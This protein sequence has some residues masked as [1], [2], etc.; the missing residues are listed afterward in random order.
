MNFG[1]V[2]IRLADLNV[3][4]AVPVFGKPGRRMAFSYSLD[5]DTGILNGANPDILTPHPGWTSG[6]PMGWFYYKTITEGC[7]SWPPITMYVFSDYTD[8]NGITH[9]TTTVT[10]TTPNPPAC[11]GDITPPGIYPVNDGSGLLKVVNADQSVSI[12]TPSGA[13]IQPVRISW[14]GTP[15]PGLLSGGSVTDT[16][17]NQI[18]FQPGTFV[19]TTGTSFSL[20]GDPFNPQSQAFA[21]TDSNGASQSVNIQYGAYNVGD[22]CSPL[23]ANLPQTV[24]YPDSSFMQFTYQ[25]NPSDPSAVTGRIASVRLQTGGTISL[26]YEASPFNNGGCAATITHITV[27]T[28][29]G[30]WDLRVVPSS[31]PD[32]SATLATTTVTDPKGNQT[33]ATFVN[34]FEIQKQMYTGSANSGTLLQTIIACYNGVKTNCTSA[35]PAGLV[36][37]LT[38]FTLLPNGMQRERDTLYNANG[39]ATEVDEYYWN[40]SSAPLNLGRKTITTYASLGNIVNR[41]ASVTVYDGPSG[42]QISQMTYGYDE[43]PL[44]ATSGLAQ[45]IP[46]SGAHGNLTSTHRWLNTSG[47]T[48]NST[49]A[50]DDA[51]QVASTADANGNVTLFAYTCNDAYPS[52]ITQPSTGFSHVTSASYDCNTGLTTTTTDQNNQT[53]KLAY[54]GF[55]RPATINYPDG[56]LTTFIHWNPNQTDRQAKM[57]SSQNEYSAVLVDGYGRVSRTAQLNGESNPWDQQDFSYDADGLLSFESYRYQGSGWGTPKVTSGAGDSFAYDGLGRILRTTHSDGTSVNYVQET[58]NTQITDESGA[59]RIIKIDGLGRPVNV[60]E[61]TTATLPGNGGTP[62]PCGLDLPGTG[63][64]T[65]YAYDVLDNLIGVQQ[66]A[67]NPRSYTYDSLSRMLSSTD[68]ES[69]TTCYGTYSGPTCQANGYDPNGNLLFKTDARGITAAYSYDALNRLTSKTYSDGTPS[70]YFAYDGPGWWGI[71]QTNTVGRLQEAWIGQPCCVTNAGI[72][73]GYDAMGRIVMTEQGSTVGSYRMMNYSYD[74]AGDLTSSTNGVGVTFNYTYNVAG[75]M[76][77]MNSSYVDANHPANLLSGAHYNAFGQRTSASYGNVSATTGIN[78]S[79]VFD[80]RGRIQSVWSQINGGAGLEAFSGVTYA[81]NGQIAGVND[82]INYGNWTYSYDDFNRLKS[83]GYT[84]GP[85]YSY[86]YDRYGNRWQQSGGTVNWSQAFDNNNH[87]VGWSYDAAG[88]LLNDGSHSYTYD[89]EGRLLSVDGGS[90]NGG[91][92]Y[93]YD[94]FGQRVTRTSASDGA[95]GFTYDRAGRMVAEYSP[96]TWLRGEVYGG[97]QHMATYTN[98]TYFSLVDWLGN[99]RVKSSQDESSEQSFANLPFGDG[100]GF[101]GPSVG[102]AGRIEFTGDEHDNESNL[103]HTLWRQY[104]S[105]QG[106]WMSPDPAG[107][108]AA[109]LGNPQSLNRY[110]YALN[111]P[112]NLIDPLGTCPESRDESLCDEDGWT[113]GQSSDSGSRCL[114]DGVAIDCGVVSRLLGAGAAGICP[115]NDCSS[116]VLRD[117]GDGI[118][119]FYRWKVEAYM[120]LDCGA[121]SGC[122]WTHMSVSLVGDLDP[123]WWI[124]AQARY[125]RAALTKSLTAVPTSDDYINAIHDSFATF[126]DVCSISVTASLGEP[127]KDDH[128]TLSTTPQGGVTVQVNDKQKD[129]AF[130]AYKILGV[131]VEVYGN[132]WRSISGFG[133]KGTPFDSGGIS[134]RVGIAPFY[135]CPQ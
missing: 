1:P 121:S 66:G 31:T 41:P 119:S 124:T 60:C 37:E 129:D 123:L 52:Q 21:Y 40:V 53:T 132:N 125:N 92:T 75:R 36:N 89:A 13:V 94:T 106:R 99:E 23:P 24:T 22:V 69:G 6:W 29:D 43:G 2:T 67:L 9:P 51:G 109:S 18:S 79:R 110:A 103:E 8:G 98:A 28:S 101:W 48:V 19:D 58:R 7:A 81:P 133:V 90:S 127:G 130:R 128:V 88:N 5:Y 96:T 97:G 46:V 78:E 64:L 107:L 73:F 45:H 86:A 80:S 113:I 112:L 126:P 56:G 38:V 44:T 61:L 33:V 35:T 20:S 135:N 82:S 134:G 102:L 104:S 77:D 49:V 47:G 120:V 59:S 57:N 76:T 83:A 71:P 27:T 3:H 111:D 74:L 70:A 115:N 65:T 50:Y 4:V 62:A 34:G 91:T 68:P 54:D 93:T 25:Q 117:T 14:P 11:F 87:I 72:I 95:H 116:L 118:A 114:A 15:N 84:N 17:G 85:T 122:T 12:V 32:G 26:A 100:K 39:L 63:F 108:A 131:G 16:N 30:S 105:A 55:M 10:S 42:S